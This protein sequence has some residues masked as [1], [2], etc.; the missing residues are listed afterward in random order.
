M[1]L[2]DPLARS[3]AAATNRAGTADFFTVAE[4]TPGAALLPHPSAS[5]S[6]VG[7]RA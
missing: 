7:V 4:A 5:E 2:P 1:I 3:P 6:A